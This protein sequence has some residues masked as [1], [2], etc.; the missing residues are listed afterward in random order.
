MNGAADNRQ[1]TRIGVRVAGPLAE[2]VAD[3]LITAGAGGVELLD[4]QHPLPPADLPEGWVEVR[5]H[6]PG[7]GLPPGLA[8]ELERSLRQAG[9]FLPGLEYQLCGPE[10]VED[11]DWAEGWRRYFVPVTIGRFHIHP[12]WLQPPPGSRWPVRIDPGQAFGTGL[13]AT[14]R[15]CLEEMDRLLPVDSFLDAGCGSGILALAAAR[16]GC[17]RVL[18]L[19]IDEVA[20]RE[21]RRNARRN[22][23]DQHLDVVYGGLDAARGGFELVAA[24]ILSGELIAAAGLLAN[25]LLPGARLLLSGILEEE[26]DGVA[27]AYRR[28]GLRLLGRRRQGEWVL[29]SLQRPGGKTA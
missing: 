26:A 16:A 9:D 24:N 21:T 11:D 13:H 6:F 15:L 22:G 20:C 23:L 18:A 29:L 4:G 27:A 2:L 19:D 25:R 10:P 5:A 1:W 3:L 28:Q 7:R 8:D 17:R 12:G 14:T